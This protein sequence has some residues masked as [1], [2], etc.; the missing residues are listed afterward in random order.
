MYRNDGARIVL[1]HYGINPIK[2][3]VHVTQST[4]TQSC[5]IRFTPIWPALLVRQGHR[6]VRFVARNILRRGGPLEA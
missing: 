1:L 6:S 4:G 2:R 5:L 3:L